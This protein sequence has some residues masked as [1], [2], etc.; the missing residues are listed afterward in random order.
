MHLCGPDRSQYLG[1]DGIR[2]VDRYLRSG[3]GNQI[4]VGFDVPV[5]VDD[6][7]TITIDEAKIVFSQLA[8]RCVDCVRD[9]RVASQWNV[10]RRIDAV[11]AQTGS[12]RLLLVGHSMGG[13][14][15]RRYL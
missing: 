15:A 2:V 13:L 3:V 4:V 1:V 9:D 6:L 8:Q 7:A 12:D 5:A 14:V 11:L 10:A